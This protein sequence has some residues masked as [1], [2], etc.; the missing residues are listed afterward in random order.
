MSVEFSEADR[1][2]RTAPLPGIGYG[3]AWLQAFLHRG[4]GLRFDEQ[5]AADI[6]RLA[7]RTLVG[8]FDVA[9]Q[10]ALA[11]GR[12]I[13]MRHDLPL[14]KGLHARLGEAEALASEVDLKPLLCFLADAGVAAPMDSR[15]HDDIPRL[16][17]ALLLL[18]GRV[19]AILEPSDMST[20]ERLDRLLR[21][22][23]TGPTCWELERAGRV[24]GLTL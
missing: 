9:E 10:T 6:S 23:P 17:A 21:R 13:I 15:V 2:T 22:D 11:N 5:Q 8:L 19:I 1:D 3:V 7:E 14:T 4:S 20:T 12:S 16:M 24:L 18:A